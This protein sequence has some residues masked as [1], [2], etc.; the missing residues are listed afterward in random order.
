MT[1]APTDP[2][3]LAVGI[4]QP[5][6]TGAF[7]HVFGWAMWGLSAAI[8]IGLLLVAGRMALR[9]RR[10]EEGEGLGSLGL[11]LTAAVIG[12]AAGPIVNALLGTNPVG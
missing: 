7:T 5:P 12:G 2:A 11:V 4:E 9:H 10:G 8:F 6:G 1:H 3:V